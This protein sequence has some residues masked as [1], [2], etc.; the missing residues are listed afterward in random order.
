MGPAPPVRLA[1]PIENSVALEIGAP[2]ICR[3]QPVTGNIQPKLLER[4]LDEHPVVQ[5]HF[6]DPRIAVR[7]YI[8]A[9]RIFRAVILQGQLDRL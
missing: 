9:G 5:F 3:Q 8:E 7:R 2:A 6:I 1:G 4:R